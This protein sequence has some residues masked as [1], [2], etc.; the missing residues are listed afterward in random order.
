[1]YI[2]LPRRICFYRSSNLD[3]ICPAHVSVQSLPSRHPR[4]PFVS[5]RDQALE[6]LRCAF[7]NGIRV[8][9]EV[10]ERFTVGTAVAHKFLEVVRGRDAHA[11]ELDDGADHAGAQGALLT[12][13]DVKGHAGRVRA[14]AG[15]GRR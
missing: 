5:E 3:R 12:G 4:C 10:E 13:G 1:M 8:V 11:V 2:E 7:L 15:S 6:Y 9:A 14:V